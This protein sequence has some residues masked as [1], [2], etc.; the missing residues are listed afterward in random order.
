MMF[1]SAGTILAIWSHEAVRQVHDP[2][3][4]PDHAPGR[5]GTKGDDLGHL[6]LSVFFHHVV[7]DLLAAFIAEIHVDIRHGHPLR[8]QEPLKQ[9][10]VADGIDV[11]D[12]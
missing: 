9:K 6:V 11:G 12:L 10:L 1:S 3:H 7:D 5:Q 4:V 8:V 2:S